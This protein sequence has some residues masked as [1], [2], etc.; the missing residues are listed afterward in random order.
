LYCPGVRPCSSHLPG[1]VLDPRGTRYR[2]R[3]HAVGALVGPHRDDEPRDVAGGNKRY[4]PL[5]LAASIVSRLVII[6]T[7]AALHPV[8]SA[9]WDEADVDPCMEST[10][11]QLLSDI[12]IWAEAPAAPVVFWLNG[13]AGTGKSTIARTICEHF[14]KT[15]LLG[16]SFFISR[17]IAERRH[18]PNV[19]RTIVY[20]LARQ[21]RAFADA[22]SATL[23]DSPDLASS[24]GLQRLAT[25]LL[26]K[27]AGVLAADAGLVFVIDALDECTDD[28]RGRPG[29]ELLPLLLRGL[30][31][32]SGRVK[33][34]LTSRAEPAIVR[35]FENASLGMQQTVMQLHDLDSAVVRADIRTY[36]TLSFADIAKDCPDLGLLDWP[37]QRDLD[38]VAV[39]SDVLFVF[40]A[41]VVRFVGTPKQNP[42]ARL[43]I[44]LARRE[45]SSASPYRFLD[46]LYLQVL[47]TSV[48][49]EEQEDEVGSCE[50][51]KLVVGSIIAAQQPLSVAV[52]A[53]LLARDPA[54]VQLM[55]NSLSALL[56]STS[57]EPVRIFHPSFPDFIVDSR[58]CDESRFLVVLN[59]H[60]L[61]LTHGCLALLNRHLRYNIANLEDPDVA[62]SDVE[63]LDGHLHRAICH[64]EDDIGLSLPEA[65]FYAARHWAA[66]I[67]SITAVDSKLADTLT[68]FCHD[69]LLHWL[70]LLS[71]IRSLAFSIQTDLL[72]V[73]H[74]IEVRHSFPSL[75]RA[76]RS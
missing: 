75:S 28:N 33:L 22:L 10:R 26:F 46:K 23:Q 62:N 27:P 30:L 66:H 53:L 40:A 52:H 2:G 7:L 43:E 71:L 64:K 76:N 21:Q 44:M 18:A 58:R 3:T 57:S 25:E 51:L 60:H 4:A 31:Q 13:L 61:R 15:G 29:G 20:Q 12:T 49:S 47:R 16:A 59:E 6:A 32:L 1:Y 5:R 9:R 56:L 48:L 45:G 68:C 65:L 38:T 41:T 14:T 74:W 54:D 17:Q 35:M 72:A 70:E 11:E 34:L 24:E 67:V 50:L 73:I 39:L 37:S 63:D 69:H 55:I 42:R 36:L 19:L 8:H